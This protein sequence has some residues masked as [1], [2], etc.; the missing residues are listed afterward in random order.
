MAQESKHAF[1]T[2][3]SGAANHGA[4]GSAD[5]QFVINLCSLPAPITIPQP[6]ASRLSRYSFFLSH[7]W[8]DG[9]R[10]YWLHMGYFR[11]PAEADKWLA[12]LKRVYPKAHV[13]EAPQS[14]PELMSNTQRLRIL[15]I[16][17]I[18]G[19][20]SGSD[21]R[22]VRSTAAPGAAPKSSSPKPSP[23]NARP[24]VKPEAPAARSER[25]PE[26][27]I[28]DTLNELR[29]SEFDM[30]DGTDLNATGV[31]HLRFE[32]ENT[33]RAGRQPAARTRK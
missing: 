30:G 16:G 12:T 29:T 21:S 20:G 5:G 32:V 10:Q 15:D 8:E 13:A 4:E 7:C 18:G 9:R 28:E 14:Q 1:G 24:H 22:E 6:R 2:G 3:A 31:R 25:R 19:S 11:S 27:T 26:P 17:R 23:A 33:K